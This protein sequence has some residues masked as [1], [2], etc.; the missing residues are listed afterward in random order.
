MCVDPQNSDAYQVSRSLE[1]FK[2][3]GIFGR[4]PGEG[5]VKENLPDA[6]SDFI[7]A[8][9]GEEF[10]MIVGLLIILLFGFIVLRGFMRVFKETDLFIQLAVTGLLAQFGLQAIINLASTLNLMPTKGTTLPFISYGGSSL[11]AL[12]IGMGMVLALTRERPD[13][14]FYS[15]NMCEIGK[16]LDDAQ[17][18]KFH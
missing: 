2:N 18:M 11:L 15:R 9:A 16:I 1:A 17:T 7:F 13:S 10:G 14:R 5:H 12:S 4:G 3:G 8:V 6:H